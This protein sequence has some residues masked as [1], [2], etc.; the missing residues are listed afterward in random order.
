MDSTH[1]DWTIRAQAEYDALFR[2]GAPTA[3]LLE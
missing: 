1:P 2:Q 3:A